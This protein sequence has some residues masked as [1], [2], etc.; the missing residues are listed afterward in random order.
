MKYACSVTALEEKFKVVLGNLY[1][2]FRSQNASH[3]IERVLPQG[4]IIL[5]GVAVPHDEV[6]V[7]NFTDA[8]L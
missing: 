6:I 5:G 4:W 8:G 7:S 3:L 2:Y 1:V